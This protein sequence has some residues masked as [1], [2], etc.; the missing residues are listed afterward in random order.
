MD[1]LEVKKAVE[2][3]PSGVGSWT[4]EKWYLCGDAKSELFS[5]FKADFRESVAVRLTAYD[6][7]AGGSYAVISHQ[8]YGWTHRF[9]LP[10]YEPKVRTMLLDLQSAEL[11]FMFGNEGGKDAVL[12]N[13]PLGA[14]AFAP[15]FAKSN[16]L[17]KSELQDVLEELP[18]VIRTMKEPSQVPSLRRGERVT[19]VS[20][21]AVLP[22]QAMIRF[23]CEKAE[24][25][26]A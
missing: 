13:C 1:P 24:G 15:L 21:S 25:M 22:N 8:I 26:K 17:R 6:T 2:N 9:V 16:P 19:D 11:G 20:V 12:L 3:H 5:M 4:K 10:L 23:L 14:P 7:P 18:K